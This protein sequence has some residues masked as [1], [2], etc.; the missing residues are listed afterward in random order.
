MP[1]YWLLKSEPEVY[2]IDDLARDKRTR[3]EGVRNY[4]A[5]NF[6]RDELKM[7]DL[8]FFY[9][10]NT[11][12][13]GIAGIAE[14]V[15]EGYP[16]KDAYNPK[17]EYFDAKSSPEKPAWYLVD[18]GFRQKFSRL[19]TLEELKKIKAL[20]G[21]PLLARGQR[22]SVQPVSE[23]HWKIITEIAKR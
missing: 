22:L 15:R 19:I 14:V 20:E 17:S 4:Q 21:M 11:E 2:S 7:G 13:A 10:S 18:I 16:D 8:V 1:N 6:L 12:P 5:R 9:H 23:K 3:W